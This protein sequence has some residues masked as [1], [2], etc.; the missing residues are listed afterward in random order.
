MVLRLRDSAPRIPQR[1]ALSKDE[2]PRYI[3]RLN[4]QM[5]FN[6]HLS[7]AANSDEHKM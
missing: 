3:G 7:V 5:V 1:E 6:C 2:A 4:Q